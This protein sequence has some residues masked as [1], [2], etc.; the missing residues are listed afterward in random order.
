MEP[1]PLYI[2][3][4]AL[5]IPVLAIL[6]GGL[7]KL[8]KARS[9]GGLGPEVLDQLE[10]LREELQQVRGELAEVQERLDFTERLLARQERKDLPGA[11]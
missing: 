3:I 11:S 6:F 7:V 1:S 8:Q 10:E 2:P 5:A 9:Q 4:L